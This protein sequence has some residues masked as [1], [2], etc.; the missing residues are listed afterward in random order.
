MCRAYHTLHLGFIYKTET[1]DKEIKRFNSGREI[2]T[3]TEFNSRSNELSNIL[4]C[5]QV[6]GMCD[7][8]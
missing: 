1:H 8:A 3:S 2:L 4:M 6:N 7:Y 5:V